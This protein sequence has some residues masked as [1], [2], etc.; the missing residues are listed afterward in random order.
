MEVGSQQLEI[1][2]PLYAQVYG[3]A[4]LFEKI[5]KGA[6]LPPESGKEQ[7]ICILNSAGSLV[8][9]PKRGLILKFSGRVIDPKKGI[10]RDA[11]YWGN[12]QR[13]HRPIS[14]VECLASEDHGVPR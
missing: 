7:P 3:M 13:P 6:V 8:L 5:R 14:D 9:D 12:F 2:Q 4:I 10:P 11:S 1:E